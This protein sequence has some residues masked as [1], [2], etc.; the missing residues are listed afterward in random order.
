MP[1]GKPGDLQRARLEAKFKFRH[2]G[3][4]DRRLD[5]VLNGHMWAPTG[6]ILRNEEWSKAIGDI[7]ADRV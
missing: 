5:L 6:L 1:D 2:Q 3:A 4:R 7:G